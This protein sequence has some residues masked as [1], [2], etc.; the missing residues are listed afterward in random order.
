M[1]TALALLAAVFAGLSL[2]A[3]GGA[4]ALLPEMQRQAAALGWAD[5]VQ[6]AAMFALAQAAPGPNMLVVTL[7]GWRVAGLPGAAVATV[8]FVLPAAVLTYT[9]SGLWERFRAAP[10]R[11]RVQAGL[12]PVTVGL[13]MAAALLL[14]RASAHS[15]GTALVA[16]ASSVALLA[17]R[18]H[19]LWLLALGGGLGAAGVLQ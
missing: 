19:P 6:F 9:V 8:A 17:T 1:T 7:I 11:A 13:V 2:L 12:T 18:L 16:L 14:C 15:P 3:V 4:N 5:P 10:W